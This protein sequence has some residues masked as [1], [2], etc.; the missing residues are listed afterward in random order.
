MHRAAL[1][2]VQRRKVQRGSA[3]WGSTNGNN[4]ERIIH[5]AVT[6]GARSP[7]CIHPL[8]AT[9]HDTPFAVICVRNTVA[10]AGVPLVTL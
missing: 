7:D 2:V 5:T 1:F 8:L 6:K 9:R 3:L 10:V 4:G